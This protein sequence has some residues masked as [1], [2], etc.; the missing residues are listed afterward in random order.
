[1][2]KHC[3]SFYNNKEKL[4]KAENY[5][6]ELE[7]NIENL[8]RTIRGWIAKRKEERKMCLG[9]FKGRIKLYDPSGI[10]NPFENMN[11]SSNP[12]TAINNPEASPYQQEIHINNINEINNNNNDKVI[13]NSKSNNQYNYGVKKIIIP[14][15]IKTKILKE[16]KQISDD[17]VN[18][19][20]DNCR[21]HSIAA[22]LYFKQVI[23]D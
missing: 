9:T 14:D 18:N 8:I 16:L 1:M 20:V 21:Q 3:A 12:Y 7:K 2:E 11:P 22:L 4:N 19:K 23:P 5:Y 6:I 13:L 17:I 10:Q 15:D